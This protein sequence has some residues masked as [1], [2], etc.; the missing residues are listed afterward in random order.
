MNP[1]NKRL[2]LFFLGLSVV[3]TVQS[4]GGGDM[5][6]SCY[7]GTVVSTAGRTH[8]Q[9]EKKICENGVTQCLKNSGGLSAGSHGAGTYIYGCGGKT[10][11]EVGCVKNDQKLAG[12][13]TIKNEKCVCTGNLCNSASTKGI[14]FIAAFSCFIIAYLRFAV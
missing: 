7:E 4:A 6:I 3:S 14:N 8:K 12:L 10:I 13:V 1:V 2:F 5:T 9:L 11:N